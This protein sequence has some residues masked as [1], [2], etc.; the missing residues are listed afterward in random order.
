VIR[1]RVM[2]KVMN[3]WSSHSDCVFWR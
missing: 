2:K 3:F 1:N